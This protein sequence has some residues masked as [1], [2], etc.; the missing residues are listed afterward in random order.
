MSETSSFSFGSELIRREIIVKGMS[1]SYWHTLPSQRDRPYR[2]L[3]V[4]HGSTM[5][6]EEMLTVSGEAFI[7]AVR[8]EE[9]IIS[10]FPQGYENYWNDCRKSGSYRAKR[11]QIDDI[12]FFKAIMQDLAKAYSVDPDQ[13]M[14]AGFSNGGQM[15]YKTAMTEPELFRAYAVIGAN[16]PEAGNSDCTPKEK[17]VSMLIVN[18]TS[19]PIN[20]YHGGSVE[21]D[22]GEVRGTV[23]SSRESYAYWRD[24]LSANRAEVSLVESQSDTPSLD[25]E[26]TYEKQSG[27]SVTLVSIQDGGHVIHNPY[28]TQWPASVGQVYRDLNIP[29]LVMAFLNTG[30]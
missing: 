26:S 8:S 2:L 14:I 23:L 19:D 6:V 17:P 20:L 21:V 25:I 27:K 9:G 28:F 4:L 10:V 16:M 30:D 13:N 12:L 7:E 11:E 3:F 18:G 24:L 22:D 29:K 5:S 15:V 1:R